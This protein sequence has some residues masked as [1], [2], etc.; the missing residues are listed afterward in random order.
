MFPVKFDK[1]HRRHGFSLI[2]VELISPESDRVVERYRVRSASLANEIVA[3]RGN[4]HIVKM[5]PECEWFHDPVYTRR[6]IDAR[7]V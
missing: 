5:T 1:R 6:M 4:G 7:Y 3:R 2:V